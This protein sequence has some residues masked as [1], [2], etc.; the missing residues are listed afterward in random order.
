MQQQLERSKEALYP[1][2]GGFRMTDVLGC[3]LVCASE[4]GENCKPRTEHRELLTASQGNEVRVRVLAPLI[5]ALGLRGG[6]PE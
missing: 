3:I 4:T 6:S 1:E 2:L 5:E